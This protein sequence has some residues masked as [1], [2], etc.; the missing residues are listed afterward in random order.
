M[1][2]CSG[3]KIEK[4]F[5][6]FNKSGNKRQFMHGYCKPCQA[7]YDRGYRLP[8][9]FGL[10]MSEYN[11]LFIKQEGKC[12]ICNVHQ[13]EFIKALAVDHNHRTNKVRGLLCFACNSA[14]G[15]LKESDEIINNALEYLRKWR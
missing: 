5:D 7:D 13:S 4:P 1:K 10:S 9:R 6:H 8:K 12:A 15:K 14:I 3:C 11:E 2:T